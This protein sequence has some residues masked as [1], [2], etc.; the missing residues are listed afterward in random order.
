[1]T[2]ERLRWTASSE[3]FEI[4][5]TSCPYNIVLSQ[6][7]SSLPQLRAFI[8]WPGNSANKVSSVKTIGPATPE[9]DGIFSGEWSANSVD[10]IPASPSGARF[11]RH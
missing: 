11:L 5:L 2:Q 3:Y 9:L 1:M 8:P 4:D 7:S 10:L 6:P